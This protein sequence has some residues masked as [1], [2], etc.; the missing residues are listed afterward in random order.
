MG[1][2]GRQL[3]SALTATEFLN[4]GFKAGPKQR[5]TR[6]KKT[7]TRPPEEATSSTTGGEG[8]LGPPRVVPQANLTF[9]AL[10]VIHG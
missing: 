1:G 7:P 8:G 3:K 5:S 10:Q 4:A 9:V 2:R 6:V